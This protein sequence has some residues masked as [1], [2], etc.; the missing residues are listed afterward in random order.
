ME[1]RRELHGIDAWFQN[2]FEFNSGRFKC[3]LT[4]WASWLLELLCLYVFWFCRL[5][6]GFIQLHHNTYRWKRSWIEIYLMLLDNVYTSVWD[7]SCVTFLESGIL[8]D[9]TYVLCQSS[10]LLVTLPLQNSCCNL[11]KGTIWHLGPLWLTRITDIF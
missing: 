4:W 1:S 11:I 2:N 5:W 9:T 3:E 6:C 10:S 8:N 7:L